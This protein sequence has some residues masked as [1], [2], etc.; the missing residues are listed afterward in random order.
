MMNKAVL[1]IF[2]IVFII[3]ISMKCMLVS[4]YTFYF[5]AFYNRDCFKSIFKLILSTKYVLSAN[6][7]DANIYFFIYFFSFL[8]VLAIT[9]YS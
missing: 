3:Y 8:G 4:N 9:Q 6:V 7:V 1:N 2:L 5:S